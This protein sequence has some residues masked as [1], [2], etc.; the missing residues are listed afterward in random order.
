M[1]SD[2][3]SIEDD[4]LRVVY[5]LAGLRRAETNLAHMPLVFQNYLANLKKFQISM[6]VYSHNQHVNL[7]VQ[8]TQTVLSIL[9][10]Y[11][12]QERQF[13]YVFVVELLS[14]ANGHNDRGT[15]L[16]QV[17]MIIG[18]LNVRAMRA[19]L[20]FVGY[21]IAGIKW[22]KKSMLWYQKGIK[23]LN[24]Y[25]NLNQNIPINLKSISGVP[26]QNIYIPRPC[27]YLAQKPTFKRGLAMIIGYFCQRSKKNNDL[28]IKQTVFICLNQ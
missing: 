16:Q 15:L 5:V 6:L 18:T 8:L 3:I 24:L 27:L 2:L 14:A 20:S 9:S 25:L 1:S 19:G 28:R 17:E 22:K 12:L 26:L 23:Y 13:R 7:S 4:R 21:P 11:Q 10:K